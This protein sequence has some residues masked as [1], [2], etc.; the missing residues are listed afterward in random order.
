PNP[1]APE[2]AR[3]LGRDVGEVDRP[4][5]KLD[6]LQILGRLLM[7]AAKGLAVPHQKAARAVGQEEPLVRIEGDRVAL[8]DPRHERVAAGNE[9]E[10]PAVRRVAMYPEVVARGE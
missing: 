8:L 10:E 5:A 6:V 9:A 4:L 2:I 1:Q 3:Q 7:C